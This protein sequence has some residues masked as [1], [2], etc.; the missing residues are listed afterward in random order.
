MYKVIPNLK[1]LQNYIDCV[2]MPPKQKKYWAGNARQI[3]KLWSA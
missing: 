2:V 3:L 1:D